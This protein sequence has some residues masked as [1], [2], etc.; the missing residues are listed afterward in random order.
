MEVAD[1]ATSL[2]R[3]Q[4]MASSRWFLMRSTPCEQRTLVGSSAAAA[5]YLIALLLGVGHSSWASALYLL[6]LGSLVMCS[7]LTWRRWRIAVTDR[8][9]L[10]LL[11]AAITV[12]TVANSVYVVMGDSGDS[13]LAWQPEVFFVAFYILLLAALLASVTT[14]RPGYRLTFSLG[15]SSAGLAVAAVMTGLFAY[16]IG[17]A[18]DKPG[19]TSVYVALT[20]AYPSL[21]IFVCAIIIGLSILPLGVTSLRWSVISVG[22]AL[23]AV[24]DSV[25]AARLLADK[26]ELGTPFDAIWMIGVCVITWGMWLR[27]L[28]RSSGERISFWA[29]ALPFSS[30]GV[31]LLV[32]LSTPSPGSSGAARWFA[33]IAI[34]MVA[35]W[36]SAS[37]HEYG[38]RVRMEAL[39]MSDALTGLRNRRYADTVLNTMLT[40]RARSAT[41][42]L[43]LLDID[44]FKE[45]NDEFGH[46]VGD[47]ALQM[48]A[49][50][51]T[52]VTRPADLTARLG[53]DEFLIV[54]SL[55]DT[56]ELAAREIAE[57]TID[58]LREQILSR[59]VRGRALEISVG[60]ATYPRDG[61]TVEE[62]LHTADTAMYLEKR[63]HKAG[64]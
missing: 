56:D 34:L 23:F 62:L 4:E 57:L 7:F 5:L 50:A 18:G 22:L 30:V 31:C 40:M 46:A 44:H 59:R 48:V 11:A 29:V 21:D 16:E 19:H 1:S 41:F 9:T 45:I 27:P 32:L 15:A 64:L 3:G 28:E 14:I 49:T 17:L 60:C 37:S 24:G 10:G 58:R 33:A 55:F 26:H 63:R 47:T 20:L 13:G 36:G 61:E 2:R 39:A 8:W 25:F 38:R 51:M 53:G 12:Y 43:L 42:V 52:E 35:I 54:L 6:P